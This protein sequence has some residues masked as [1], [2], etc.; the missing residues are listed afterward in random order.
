MESS[1]GRQ[2]RVVGAGEKVVSDTGHSEQ[3]KM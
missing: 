2:K 3:S 1:P